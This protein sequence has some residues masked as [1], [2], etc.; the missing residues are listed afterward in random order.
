MRFNYLIA[1]AAVSLLLAGGAI[2][3]DIEHFH[4]KGMG[5]PI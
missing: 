3:A 1:G 2:A 4:P 5:R